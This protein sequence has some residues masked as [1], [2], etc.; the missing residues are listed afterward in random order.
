M[1]LASVALF[2]A[3]AAAE[4]RRG[5]LAEPDDAGARVRGPPL[6]P[7]HRC[8]LVWCKAAAA[9]AKAA[10]EGTHEAR[11]YDHDLRFAKTRDDLL[12]PARYDNVASTSSVGQQ[13]LRG[14][15]WHKWLPRPMSRVGFHEISKT[16]RQ[17]AKDF[18]S[19][20]GYV[21]CVR[22]SLSDVLISSQQSKVQQLFGTAGFH[23]WVVWTLLWDESKLKVK[24]P[25]EPPG[26]QSIL[27][28]HA[29]AHW[30]TPGMVTHA[31]E[32]VMPPRA[33]DRCTASNIMAGLE[34]T[35]PLPLDR[36]LGPGLFTCLQL[37]ADSAA[38]NILVMKY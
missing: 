27:V 33:I 22:S 3:R 25:G 11:Q 17:A 14:A 5:L 2:A 20:H 36:I 29:I 24:V 4:H 16:S 7:L 26:M 30:E 12:F 34:I 28:Q 9:A 8:R 18:K 19:S 10:R 21:Q 15:G 23:N 13:R 35:T 1:P 37:G 6:V 32:I 38:S 31:R